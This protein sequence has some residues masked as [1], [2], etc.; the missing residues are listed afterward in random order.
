MLR[1][2]TSA[3]DLVG[4]AEVFQYANS[5]A[6]QGGGPP[7]FDLR[8]ISAE[9]RIES[10][11]GLSLAGY[12]RLPDRIPDEAMVLLIGCAGND[13]DFSSDAARTAV[14]WLRAQ[15]RPHH[16]LLCICT[17]ALMAGHAGLLDGR[18]CTT[19]HNHCD[20]LRKI[21]PL[22]R[23]QENRIFVQDGTVYTSAGVTAGIDLAFHVL[24]QIAGYQ[25]SAA[26]ARKMVVYMRRA[27]TDPQLS[28]W[29]A[30]RNHLHPAIHRV[31]DA[32][33]G[34]P[35]GDWSVAELARVACTSERHL[36]RLFREHAGTGVV[37]YLQ[38]IRVA[39]ARELLMQSQLDME[40]V[41]ERSGFNSSRQLRRIWKKFEAAPPSAYRSSDRSALADCV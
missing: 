1:E 8:Y 14:A 10:S 38:R 24:A 9:S 35:A 28:P 22:A 6:V 29:L 11:I 30:F 36:T 25:F 16:R 12:A 23:V 27:G 37:D 7:L 19:H 33:L 20:S 2:N 17:G 4:P 3:L 18:Q 34:D 15:V 31:Q 21:A 40:S 39:L 5:L 13:D 26:I 32:I 41:A